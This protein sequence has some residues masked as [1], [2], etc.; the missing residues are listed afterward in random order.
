MHRSV[1]FSKRAS[2]LRLIEDEAFNGRDIINN[3]IV[4]ENGQEEF[5]FLRA[6][7]IN[8]GIQLSSKLE[9]YFLKIG[10]NS[11]RSMKFQKELQSCVSGYRDIY[12]QLTNQPLSQELISSFILP[13]NK[14]IEISLSSDESDFELIH[15]KKMIAL[16]YDE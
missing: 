4:Y 14:S 15:Q 10:I 5:D 6:D 16:D 2:N 1:A 8:A 12:K 7:K 13:K 9:K 3:L 11:E